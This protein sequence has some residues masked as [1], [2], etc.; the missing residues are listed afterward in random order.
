MQEFENLQKEK[1]RDHA[2]QERIRSKYHASRERLAAELNSLQHDKCQYEW[3]L[4][5]HN[6][7]RQNLDDLDPTADAMQQFIDNIT[8]E[9][10][11]KRNAIDMLDEEMKSREIANSTPQKSNRTPS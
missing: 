7:K 6:S 10:D 5:V 2:T 11:R 1:D 9:V 3:Q 8:T 4:V